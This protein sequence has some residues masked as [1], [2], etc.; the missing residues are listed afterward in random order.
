MAALG[1]TSKRSGLPRHFFQ[2]VSNCIIKSAVLT[3][4]LSKNNRSY[5]VLVIS[6]QKQHPQAEPEP[7]GMG[8][9]KCDYSRTHQSREHHCSCLELSLQI[10]T[11]ALSAELCAGSSLVFASQQRLDI[12]ASPLSSTAGVLWEN[13]I[14]Q[15][16]K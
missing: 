14:V 10:Q 1:Q 15:S 5:R 13:K 4:G 9:E 2:P 6:L 16:Y 11:A 8:S 12:S 7:C 3:S